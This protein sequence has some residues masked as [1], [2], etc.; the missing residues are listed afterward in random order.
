[1]NTREVTILNELKSEK[2]FEISGV[3]IVKLKWVLVCIYRYPHSDVN[4]FLKKLEL[5]IDRIYKQKV[6]I[7][8]LQRLEHRPS[9]QK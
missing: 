9:P 5:L 2:N 7:N 3:E 8:N 4:I 6:K 1:V